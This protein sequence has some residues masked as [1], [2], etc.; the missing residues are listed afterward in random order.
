MEAVVEVGE[1]V[2]L[3]LEIQA[4]TTVE[5]SHSVFR[6]AD[7]WPPWLRPHESKHPTSSRVGAVNQAP[8]QQVKP[9]HPP[10]RLQPPRLCRRANDLQPKER[11]PAR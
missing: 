2:V 10:E 3:G 11:N 5:G 1:G 8:K 4:R 6:S 9:L 7:W